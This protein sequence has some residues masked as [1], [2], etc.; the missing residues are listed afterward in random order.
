MTLTLTDYYLIFRNAVKHFPSSENNCTQLQ[1]F[2]VL[3]TPNDLEMSADNLGVVPS[4]KDSPFFWSRL[5]HRNK[6]NP[7]QIGFEYP[8]LTVFELTGKK[9]KMGREYELEIAVLDKF[10][11]ECVGSNRAY[12]KNRAINQIYID[13]D[14]LLT[15]A[16]KYMD[17]SVIAVTNVDA[18]E[19]VYYLPFLQE[20][21]TAGTI[22]SYEVR[23]DIGSIIALK[24]QEN[25]FTRVEKPTIQVYG[26]KTVLKLQTR[27]CPTIEYD[28]APTDY[29]VIGFESGCT[30]C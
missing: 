28:I 24:A 23:A 27:D 15:S 1:S 13:T 8:L 7:N 10:G 14:A 17:K 9:N 20:M 3:H 5:W 25:Y 18:V 30:N 6:Y 11:F 21:K 29:G 22:T 4:E 26:T 16:I 12:C 2:R 19:R